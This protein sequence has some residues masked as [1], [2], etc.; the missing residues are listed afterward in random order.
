MAVIYGHC[1]AADKY[2]EIQAAVTGVLK[3]YALL[4][5]NRKL[6]EIG[7]VCSAGRYAYVWVNRGNFLVICNL[8]D[9]ITSCL[10]QESDIG[11]KIHGDSISVGTTVYSS[12]PH[13]ERI[14][15]NEFLSW[16]S[17]E[18]IEDLIFFD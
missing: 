9:H 13:F 15:E 12:K 1:V 18:M 8:F 7:H 6:G 14:D 16:I 2:L 17:D 5:Y 11:I 3:V 4:A 10:L